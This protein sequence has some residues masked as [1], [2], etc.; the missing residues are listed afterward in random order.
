MR[1]DSLTSDIRYRNPNGN[2]GFTWADKQIPETLFH[3]FNGVRSDIYSLTFK[4]TSYE[5]FAITRIDST[6][7]TIHIYNSKNNTND[8]E[9][10]TLSS[11]NFCDTASGPVNYHSANYWFPYKNPYWLF[12]FN[13]KLPLDLNNVPPTCITCTGLGQNFFIKKIDSSF[14]FVNNI[15][16]ADLFILSGYS[17][18]AGNAME[19]WSTGQIMFIS[20]QKGLLK[21]VTESTSYQQNY[22]NMTMDVIRIRLNQNTN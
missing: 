8:T 5:T 6:R 16:R 19:G 3:Y 18:F 15:Y 22:G 14:S 2:T 20:K 21:S 12:S 13:Y 11:I 1:I 7:S 10:V 17:Y 4:D 9:Y